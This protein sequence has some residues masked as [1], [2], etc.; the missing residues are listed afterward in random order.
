MIKSNR[1]FLWIYGSIGTFLTVKVQNKSDLYSRQQS[2]KNRGQCVMPGK[3]M[4][5]SARYP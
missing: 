3:D 1:R 4:Q 2:M 5:V